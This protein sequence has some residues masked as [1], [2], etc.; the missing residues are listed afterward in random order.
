ML[1]FLIDINYIR[2]WAKSPGRGMEPGVGPAEGGLPSE[3]SPHSTPIDVFEGLGWK[4]DSTLNG[5][6]QGLGWNKRRFFDKFLTKFLLHSTLIGIFIGLGWNE[7]STLNRTFQGL[8][9]S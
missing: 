4:G 1:D 5:T 3:K 8:G 7:G 2:G 9:W 6:F